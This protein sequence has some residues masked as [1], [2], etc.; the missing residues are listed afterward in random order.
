M[1]KKSYVNFNSNEV[2]GMKL[3]PSNGFT[4]DKIRYSELIFD[5]IVLLMLSCSVIKIHDARLLVGFTY[6]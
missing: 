6:E 5:K 1:K 3:H 4:D 2:I